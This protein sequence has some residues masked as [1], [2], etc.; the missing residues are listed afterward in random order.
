M[1]EGFKIQP[2]STGSVLDNPASWD[3]YIKRSKNGKV[4]LFII[5]QES[6]EKFGWAEILDKNIYDKVYFMSLDDL[7]KAHWKVKY[8]G[9]P[10]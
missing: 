8:D 6:L 5:T 7:K 9:L 2:G 3:V 10:K 1:T 4:K